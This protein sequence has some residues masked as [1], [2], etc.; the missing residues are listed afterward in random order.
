[1]DTRE[2]ALEKS[3]SIKELEAE[4][5][6]AE[7]SKEQKA[8]AIREAKAMY[9]KDWKKVLLGAVKS[10]RVDRETLHTLHGMGVDGV[11]RG[12]N[13]PRVFRK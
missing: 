7:L 4:E 3:I 5:L 12:Y 13:D 10:L 6:D 9:G 8:A 11:L 2:K 1:M